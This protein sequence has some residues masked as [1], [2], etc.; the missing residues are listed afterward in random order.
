MGLKTFFESK[1]I[2]ELRAQVKAMPDD[3]ALHFNLGAA[4]EKNGR[5]Q[6]AICEFEETLKHNPSSA[7]AHYNLAILYESMNK[8]EKAVLHI[9]K[10][11]N[12]FG[13]KNDSVNKTETR[14]LLRE[15]YRKFDINPKDLSPD[16]FGQ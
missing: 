8:G 9:L 5:T 1:E 11:G 15:F 14:G 13:E 6:E 3:P 2:K 10:A 16:S 12:L 4:Y 7:E